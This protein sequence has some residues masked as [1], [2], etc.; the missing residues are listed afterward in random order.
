MLAD[1]YSVSLLCDLLECP[2]SSYYYQPKLHDENEVKSAIED[3]VIE[4]PTYGYRRVTKQ[5]H[6]NGRDVNHKRVHRLMREMG[7]LVKTKRK[8]RKTTN[9]QHDFPRYP[10]LV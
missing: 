9:S 8:T 10:K 2:R 4:W 7:L 5:L 3:V 1:D 6:R